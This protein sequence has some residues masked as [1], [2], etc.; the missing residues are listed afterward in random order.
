MVKKL[1]TFL[2]ITSRVNLGFFNHM[3][4]DAL[5]CGVLWRFH[6]FKEPCPAV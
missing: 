3:D 5:A 1:R 6:A 4:K 2:Q